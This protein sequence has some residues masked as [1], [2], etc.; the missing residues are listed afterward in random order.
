MKRVYT[1]PE[2]INY[3]RMAQLTQGGHGQQLDLILDQNYRV[4]SISN[5]CE[6]NATG[7]WSMAS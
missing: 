6:S 3:G 7:C 1:R 5:N 2:L 4:I